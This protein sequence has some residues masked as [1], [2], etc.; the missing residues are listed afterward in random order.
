MKIKDMR[1]DLSKHIPDTLTGVGVCSAVC[2]VV[3][4]V[5]KSPEEREKELYISLKKAIEDPVI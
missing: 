1:L 3:E 5:K 2:N 4:C